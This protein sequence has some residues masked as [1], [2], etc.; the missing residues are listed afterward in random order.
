MKSQAGSAGVPRAMRIQSLAL[1]YAPCVTFGKL[2]WG[3]LGLVQRQPSN[4]PETGYHLKRI[5]V[6]ALIANW[7]NF[8]L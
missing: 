7:T 3:V 1:R 6:I 2:K 8:H 4:V 5:L